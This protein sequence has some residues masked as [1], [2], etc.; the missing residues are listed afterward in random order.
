M[1]RQLTPSEPGGRNSQNGRNTAH[2][3]P[4]VISK[5]IEHR[6]AKVESKNVGDHNDQPTPIHEN[7]DTNQWKYQ[8]GPTGN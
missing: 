6:V 1:D 5:A 4:D 3:R 7:R 2:Q 8:G